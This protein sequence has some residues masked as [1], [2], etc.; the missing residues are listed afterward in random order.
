MENNISQFDDEWYRQMFGS[1]I[2][3]R[4]ACEYTDI[5]MSEIDEIVNSENNPY[6]KPTL[7][8][9]YRDDVYDPWTGSIEELNEFFNWLNTL[10]PSIKFTMKYGKE[11]EYLDTIVYDVGGFIHTK[12]HSKPSDTHAYLM[13]SSCHPLH[14]CESIP[15]SVARRVKKL[16]SEHDNYIK[17]KTKFTE[18][19]KDRGYSEE[20]TKA[21]F[22][23]FEGVDRKSL[24]Q[25]KPKE[26]DNHK[27]AYP[28]VTEYN[29]KLPKISTVLNKHK[30]ILDLDTELMK[31]IPKSSI[32]AS[33]RQPQNIKSQLTR[34]G[35]KSDNTTGSTR[36]S[37]ESQGCISCHNCILCK[38][39]LKECN[40]FSSYESPEINTIHKSITCTTKG[41]I[42]MIKDLKCQRTYIGSTINEMRKRWSNYKA[43]IKT[44]YDKCEIA[45][46][47][48]THPN[49]HPLVSKIDDSI[50]GHF[51][52]TLIDK[53]DLNIYTTKKEKRAA[54]EILEGK[55][56][57]NLRTLV[58]YGGLNKRDERKISNK[59]AC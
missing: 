4:D 8:D 1:A 52:V 9:R 10:S 31:A 59:R 37:N 13:P 42:Y 57:T 25:I 2:G 34:S 29:P 5:A 23:K 50:K 33:F 19:L 36:T 58:R 28:L 20:S 16:N 17:S 22:D 12:M 53:I 15:S 41:I 40:T 51:E 54:I 45:C 14:I 18:Y 21:A 48:A 55:W 24:Y 27:K 3:P 38:N 47:V 35:F 26:G 6:K 30:Y 7:W 39:Y 11:V 49:I 56:Q 32:F 44:N 46:H 43:H